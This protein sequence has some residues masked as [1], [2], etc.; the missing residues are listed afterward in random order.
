MQELQK[1]DR[2][3][4]SVDLSIARGLAYYTGTVYETRFSEYPDFPSICGGGRYD[5]LVG[6]FV[7]KRLPGIGISIGLSRIFAK[8]FKENRIQANKKSPTE[9][10]VIHSK[11]AP[12]EFV[13]QT[14]QT[15]R[16]RGFNVEQYHEDRKLNAQLK[17][18]EGKGIP[19]IWFPPNEAEGEHQVK[20]SLSR[21]QELADPTTWTP[22][23][24]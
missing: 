22:E 16:R 8:L 2:E 6:D 14:A 11:G 10:L 20:N 5:D 24:G 9:I 7:N 17:Y 18:A 21:I 4:F 3:A 23:K 13:N 15:L 12:Y 1:I 19:W